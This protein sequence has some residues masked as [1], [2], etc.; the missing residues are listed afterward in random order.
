MTVEERDDGA[1]LTT[2]LAMLRQL[3]ARQV[4]I[5]REL[6]SLDPVPRL[7]Q[8]V[9]DDRLAEW[10]RLL[11]ASTTQARAVLQRVVQGRIVF[12]PTGTTAREWTTGGTLSPPVRPAVTSSRP[13]PA[14]SSVQRHRCEATHGPAVQHGGMWRHW[15]CR[16]I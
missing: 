4:S 8:Q 5:Q 10:R 7:P 11:R 14:R 12:H 1:G 15:A 13:T 2:V 3:E 16:H 6:E 9:I